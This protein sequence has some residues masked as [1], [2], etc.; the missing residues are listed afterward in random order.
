M[1]RLCSCTV[2]VLK[3]ECAR[4]LILLKIYYHDPQ[5]RVFPSFVCYPFCIVLFSIVYEHLCNIKRCEDPGVLKQSIC[6]PL[7]V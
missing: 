6:G 5:M 2:L 1:S 3:V 7:N 4:Q